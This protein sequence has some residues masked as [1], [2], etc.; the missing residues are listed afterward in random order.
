MATTKNKVLIGYSL[1]WVIGFIGKTVIYWG[2]T[3]QPLVWGL[4]GGFFE[5]SLCCVALYV[6]LCFT[7]YF[8][9]FDMLIFLL[10]VILLTLMKAM[11]DILKFLFTR[12]RY[13][14]CI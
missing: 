3:N 4:P 13:Y 2:G 12:R 14:L 6:A 1:Y 8:C 10:L 5:C 7:L 9:H 11:F